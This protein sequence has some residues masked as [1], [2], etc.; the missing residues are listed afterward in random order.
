[1]HTPRWSLR[2]RLVALLSV[3]TLASWAAGGLW[4]YR[5]SLAESSRLFDAA[6]AETAH[7]ILAVVAHEWLDEEEDVE[8][9]VIDHAHAETLYYQVR[10]RRG[11]I[12][13]RSPGAPSEPFDEAAARGFADRRISAAD[14]RVYSLQAPRGRGAIH[15]AQPLAARSAVARAAALRLLAPGFVF[16]LLLAGGAWLIVRKVTAPV[17]DFSHAIDART[18]GDATPVRTDALPDEL[19]P[20]GLAVNRLLA[21]V[22]AALLH[23]RTL[24]ADA[25]HELR[26]PLAALRAQAQVALRSRIDAERSEAL[27]ELI[28]GVDRAARGVDAVLTLA[29]LDAQRVD[30]T[31]LPAVRL[32]AL[33]GL[34]AAEFEAAAR[35]RG[36]ALQVDVPPLEVRGDADALAILLRNLLDNALRHAA[37][38]V[39]VQA[40]AG[41]TAVRLAVR[42]DGPGMTAEQRDRA[43]DRFY[44]G[45]EGGGAGLGLALVKRI[46]ELH[47]GSAALVDGID[48]RGVGIEVVLA[49]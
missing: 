33:A 34:V 21:R 48:G 4:L 30:S 2:G 36:V 28:G 38:V 8:L 12:V 20:V 7:A 14:Y 40:R 47:G 35:A 26:T 6:L 5:A 43:F 17:V 37:S 24:T 46:A 32:S 13:Y 19:A 1:M 9:E 23:E 15:V 11:A 22:E 27:R 29:R 10:D 16:A 25:A 44:R 45:A 31:A 42:D 18:P 49:R 41:D 39:R 3:A